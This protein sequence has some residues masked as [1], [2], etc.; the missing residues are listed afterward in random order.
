MGYNDNDAQLQKDA[1]KG[2]NMDSDTGHRLKKAFAGLH[3][4]TASKGNGGDNTCFQINHY[5]EPAVKRDGKGDLQDKKNQWYDVCGK[6]YA[7]TGTEVTMG[8]Y[9]PAGAV[10]AINIQSTAK[11]ARSLWCR[12]SKTEELPGIRSASDTPWAS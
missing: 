5:D 6:E 12:V 7:V 1:D 4:G 2:C 9:A 8:A 10:F 3:I 11:A